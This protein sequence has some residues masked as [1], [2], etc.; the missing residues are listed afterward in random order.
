MSDKK[1]DDAGG[2]SQQ[3]PRVWRMPDTLLIMFTLALLAWA[4]TF[5]FVPGQFDVAGDPARIVPGSY[6]AA[7]GTMPAPVIGNEER[8]GFL[9]FFY[10][11]LV[12]GDRYSPTVGLMAFIIVIGGAF[13]MIMRTGAIDA[14]VQA[15]LPGGKARNEILLMM[16]F[17]AFSLGGA[18]FGLSEEAIALTLILAPS[19]SRAG[20]DAI[21]ALL[22]SL[23]ASQIGFAT[24]WMNPFSVVIAQ[25]ISG[26][27][28]MSGMGPRLAVWAGFTLLGAL[29]TWRY[30]RSVRLGLRPAVRNV[31]GS[32]DAHAGEA[33]RL[34]HILVLATL[35]LGVAWVA[36]GVTTRGYYLPEIAAQF[37]AVGIATAIIARFGKLEGGS[38]SEMM[39]AFRDGAA[40]LLP[41]ALIVGAAKGI[42]LLLGGDSPTGPSLLNALLNGLA[43]LTAT[44][45]DWMTAWTMYLA[46]SVF[47]FAVSSG[48]GQASIT[49]PIMAPLA[50]LSGVTRQTAVLAF[51]LGDGFTN[52]VVPT[53]AT[54]IGC[55]AAARVSYGDWL[56]FFWR[57]MLALF[58]IGS[59]VMLLAHTGGF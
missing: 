46:Q 36:W 1:A 23:C 6:Q 15:S 17:F 31:G 22:V 5:I 32:I 38:I 57:P 19:L 13:G 21:T 25:S 24:S 53:S 49:M 54:L 45:P 8:A 51:Q 52:L 18:I 2:A 4:A 7:S 11:G 34:P 29:F 35:L 55:L 9:D 50:D 40:Q 26:L 14:A 43:G 12:T 10:A 3:T 33:L 59:A 58:L 42:M 37:F 48:S 47:N 27:P 28:P 44:V 16:L 56:A 20:Y 30:A 41:A 39:E